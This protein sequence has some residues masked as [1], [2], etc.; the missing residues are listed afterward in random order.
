[1]SNWIDT[2]NAVTTKGIFEKKFVVKFWKTWSGEPG[3]VRHSLLQ[4]KRSL[5]SWTDTAKIVNGFMIFLYYIPNTLN[6][7]RCHRSCHRERWNPR[8]GSPGKCTGP[9]GSGWHGEG[10]QCQDQRF[11]IQF[12]SH[13][14][15]IGLLTQLLLAI[16]IC[17]IF[18]IW[19]TLIHIH[20]LIPL[21][22]CY[23]E[24][25]NI[26]NFFTLSFYLSSSQIFCLCSS[27]VFSRSSFSSEL[28]KT[29]PEESM[30]LSTA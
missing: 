12:E 6:A 9:A 3:P 26:D 18:R 7:T 19:Y 20:Y 30:K 13:S 15:N 14:V 1:M 27:F 11:W 10:D 16:R 2:K 5:H 23:S 28:K 8:T 21:V 25:K 29:S 17:I 22:D 24:N 4:R